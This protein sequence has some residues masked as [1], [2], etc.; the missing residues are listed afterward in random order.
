MKLKFL[1]FMLPI[2]S[3]LS[4]SNAH[5][6]V[7]RCGGGDCHGSYTEGNYNVS[8]SHKDGIKIYPKDKLVP[9][10]TIHIVHNPYPKSI[11]F[12]HAGNDTKSSSN[13]PSRHNVQNS[14]AEKKCTWERSFQD[15]KTKFLSDCYVFDTLKYVK[16]NR[17]SVL[18][19]PK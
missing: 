17:L 12:F 2:L 9:I 4:I 6:V 19:E 15:Q 18:A 11:I 14:T 16:E 10:E 13:N 8:L 1:L 5:S 3:I 7:L